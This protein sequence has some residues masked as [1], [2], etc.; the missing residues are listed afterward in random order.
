VQATELLLQE[1]VPRQA[2]SIDP[3]PLDEMRTAAPVPAVPVRRYRSAH[4]A[5]PHTQ[6]LSNGNYVTA[7]TNAGGGGSV[8]RGLTVTRWRR[9][10]TCDAD[11]QFIYLRD[12]RRGTVWSASH[13]PSRREAD[14]YAVTFSADRASFRRRDGDISTH[15]DIAVSTEDDVEVRRIAVQNHGTSI[16]EL[17]VTSYAEIVLTSAADDLAHPAFG[18]LFIETEYLPASATLLCHRRR[19]DSGELSAWA[20]HTLSLEGRAQG[21]VEW[22]TDRARFLGRG[23]S[24]ADPVALDGRALSGTTGIVLDPIASLRQRI[25]LPPGGTVR[26]SFAMGMA[27]DRETADALAQKYHDPSTA[28]RTFALASR[29]AGA[30]HRSLAL[31]E[32]SGRRGK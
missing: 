28:S 21:A 24:P 32:R 14:D 25:R 7:V 23:R 19:R 16:R 31:C 20:F 9:D 27:P 18:K 22:E 1:R 29:L 12:V 10:A 15:L 6:V 8:W 4:T 2:P 26:L 5:V 17:E 30:W 3:R 11:G 13:Q